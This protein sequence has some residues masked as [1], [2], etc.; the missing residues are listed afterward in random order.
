MA[1]L[2]DY[3][4]LEELGQ[5]AFATV[6]KVRHNKLGYIRAVRVLNKVI[7]QGESDPSYQKFLE[8]CILLLRLGNGN[9][10]NIVHIYQPLLKDQHAVVE[11]DYVDGQDL[12]SYM[13]SHGSFVEIDEVMS[14][15]KD[16]GGALAYCHEDIY[17]YCMDRDVDHLQT[18]PNDGSKVLIDDATKHRLIEKYQVVHNDLHPG[19]IMRKR[20]GGYILLDFGL[21]IEGN[22]VVRSSRKKNGVPEYKSPEKWR[23]ESHIS[24]QSDLYSFGVILYTMLAG[25]PPFMID[26]QTQNSFEAEHQLYNAHINERP[27]AI[28]TYRKEAFEKAHPG[29]TYE[30]DYPDWLEALILKCLEKKEEDRF[31]SGKAL[32]AFAQESEHQPMPETIVAEVVAL[33][34]ED[35]NA[36]LLPPMPSLPDETLV[37]RTMEDKSEFKAVSDV[38]VETSV[39]PQP[40]PMPVK[41]QRQD[42]G[43][44]NVSSENRKRSSFNKWFFST[45]I[46]AI[47][48]GLIIAGIGTQDDTSGGEGIGAQDN[49]SGG[50]GVGSQDDT[51]SGEGEIVPE[52]TLGYVSEFTVN[53][54]SFQMVYVQG[55]T[56]RMGSNDSEAYSR[57]QP[58]HSVTLRDYYIGET[59]VTQQLWHAVM[60]SNPSYFTGDSQRPV[61]MVSWDDCQTFISQLNDLTGKDFRLPTE[62]E[63]ESAAR[64]GNKSRGYKYSGSNTLSDVAWY[65]NNASGTT[66]PVKQKRSNEL[67]LYDMSGNVWEWCQDWYDSD[68]YSQSPSYNPAGP[69]SGSNR[70]NRGGSWGCDALGNRVAFRDNIIPVN[71]YRAL[72]LRLAL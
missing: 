36:S 4:L 42:L 40:K 23:N 51:S 49:T 27:P 20:N 17:E 15:L 29:Q 18:D 60:G 58:V 63:W 5:G 12:Y 28:Y 2:E 37:V 35:Y 50:E 55:G 38:R 45:C 33:Q 32:M 7:S 59:E 67:G 65:Y 56:F 68:Y 34:P 52:D 10:P 13:D 31:Q 48:L 57:E 19:N 46:V 26:S 14:L 66:H 8:E 53:G 39:P 71:R 24:T 1:F 70:V 30:K 61:E 44:K 9:H 25:R 21:A 62:A 3:T 16:I 11:M 43:N 54:V 72:G 69:D 22:T 47:I 6:Y 41:S 64:G